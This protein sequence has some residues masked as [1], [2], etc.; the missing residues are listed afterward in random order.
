[1]QGVKS[2]TGPPKKGQ[3]RRKQAE[4]SPK[5]AKGLQNRLRRNFF[6]ACNRPGQN[7]S[8]LK[9]SGLFSSLGLFSVCLFSKSLFSKIQNLAFFKNRVAFF[10]YQLLATLN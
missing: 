5:Q 6:R 3:N 2:K 10:S 1:M 9:R 4:K 7:K 8:F